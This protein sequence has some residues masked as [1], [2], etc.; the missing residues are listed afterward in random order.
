MIALLSGLLSL[1][2][3]FLGSYLSYRAENTKTT[4]EFA[5]KF[6]ERVNESLPHLRDDRESGMSFAALLTLAQNDDQRE[7][8]IAIGVNADTEPVRYTLANFI[9]TDEQIARLILASVDRSAARRAEVASHHLS[10]NGVPREMLANVPDES[11]LTLLQTLG[12][13]K[14]GFIIYRP[15]KPDDFPAHPNPLHT[16]RYVLDEPRFLRDAMGNH[17]GRVIGA[18]PAGTAVTISRFGMRYQDGKP[19]TW[20]ELDTDVRPHQPR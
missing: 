9:A 18:L 15:G 2:G 19:Y 6:A 10:R 5:A 20:L 1:F 16:R 11:S 13:P 12:T 7:A 17:I 4:N 3:G 8:V 14:K